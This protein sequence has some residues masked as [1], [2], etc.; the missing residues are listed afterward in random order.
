MSN[1]P[2]QALLTDLYQLT[3]ASGYFHAGMAEREAV[4]HLFFRHHPFGG[5]HAL[6]CG[7]EAVA[8][9]LENWQFTATDI[10][11]L[12]SLT[13]ANEEPLFKQGFLDYLGQLRFQCDIE[14]MPEGTIAFAHEPLL[15]ITG[16][17]LQCQLIETPLLNLM[18][19]QTLIATKAS[20]VAWAAQGEPVLEFGLRRAQ[21]IDGALSAS[22][23][24]YIGGCA[25][26]SN[27]LA[28]ARYGIPVKG[29]HAHSWVMCF[30]TELE[31]FEQYARALP[32]NCV[33]LVDTYDTLR[34][35]ERAITVGN[36]LR[37]KGRKLLGIRLDSGDLAHLSIRARELLDQAGFRDAKVFAS[38][39][40]DEYVIESLKNQG[41]AIAVWGVGTKL[42]TAYDQP[43]LGGVYKLGAL[44]SGT[45]LKEWEFKIK[46]SEQPIKVSNP[47]ILQT[48]RYL[49]RGVIKADVIYCEE[50]GCSATP[51]AHDL[52]DPTRTFCPAEP[53][54]IETIELLK[55]LFRD[56]K[57]TS[58]P[59]PIEN[60]RSRALTN[61][62]ALETRSRRLLNPQTVQVG[63]EKQL[64]T[65]KRQLIAKTR[66]QGS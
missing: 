22:R 35:V 21:G 10:A 31:S 12:A 66:S 11:Y 50:L 45:A 28:G 64:E 4:F 40:L 30:D 14:A 9:Y 48:R 55:P 1:S 16:P 60:S 18:N 13:D 58:K 32:G 25:A 19:F 6:V 34:G 20:R 23:A 51:T 65:R 15:R 47:G 24:A 5:S 29:T 41:A 53:E 61:L 56:G 27:L 2:S 42:V 17:L 63:L 7:V 37:Q 8:D 39:D 54:S 26:T 43:A 44:R 3:M 52:T 49:D 33:F 36:R 57:R 59:E 46:L 62:A 38:N